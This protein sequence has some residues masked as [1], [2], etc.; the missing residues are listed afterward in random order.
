MNTTA[1]DVNGPAAGGRLSTGDR[2][3]QPLVFVIALGLLYYDSI[4]HIISKWDSAE[5]SHGP[6]ILAVSCYLVWVKRRDFQSLPVHPAILMGTALTAA[7]CFILFAGKL[8]NTISLQHVSMIPTLLGGILLLRGWEYLKVLFIPVV[9]LIFVT[10]IIETL[11][12]A[13][14]IYF[15]LVSAWIAAQF[16]EL[17]GMPV[18]LTG[19]IIELPH[20]ALEVVKA[21]SGISHIVSLMAL[22]V[23]LAMMNQLTPL[24]KIVLVIASFF[25]GIVANGARIAI[26][27][28]YALFNEGVD[29]HGPSGIF[30]V[31]FVFFAGMIVLI[32]LSQLLS[33]KTGARS[34]SKSSGEEAESE[35]AENNGHEISQSSDDVRIMKSV[36][37][38]SI[39]AILFLVTL[40]FIHFY[41]IKPVQLPLS[42]NMFPEEISSFTSKNLLEVDERFRPFAAD[43][44]VLRMYFDASGNR[45]EVY[46]GY[47]EEQSRARKLIDYRHSWMHEGARPLTVDVAGGPVV[48]NK[49]RHGD[50]DNQADVYFWYMMD[51]R[52][53]TSQYAGKL[54]TFLDGLLKRRTGGAV[55]IVETRS[56]EEEVMPFL[57]EMVGLLREWPL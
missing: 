55:V 42:L 23:P 31:L 12:S 19:T 46:I 6:L 1:H 49:T 47:L 2:F 9:Y 52:I 36:V 18:L 26:I 48:I 16:L 33:K 34:E 51:G 50:R 13:V 39:A 30:T 45:V 29:L 24:R 56:S 14:S 28:I 54:H 57:E 17:T 21:C 27:G 5:G 3:L 37:P 20:I 35:T 41:I 38:W 44:E 25:I 7:G 10:G 15:Q 8:S 11:L 40:G 43:E 4:I 32:I 53:I 22:S